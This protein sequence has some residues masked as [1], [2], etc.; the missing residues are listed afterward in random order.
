MNGAI[1]AAPA[2]P[3]NGRVVGLL[4]VSLF[5]VALLQ[6]LTKAAV[7]PADA[8]AAVPHLAASSVLTSERA[9]TPLLAAPLPDVERPAMT[10]TSPEH[11]QGRAAAEPPDQPPR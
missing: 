4:L 3:A 1:A 2:R 9:A 5:F 11:V 8:H 7:H 10:I 6:P